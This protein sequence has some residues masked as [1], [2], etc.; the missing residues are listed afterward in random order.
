MP[1][2]LAGPDA[3]A[4]AGD[5]SEPE[6]AFRPMANN[7]RRW[8]NN[9]AGP[10]Y[11]DADCIDCH[12]CSEVAPANFQID[13][14]NGHDFVYKQPENA[15]EEELCREAKSCCPVSAIGDDG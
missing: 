13:G 5:S 4:F 15:D 12:L 1:G 8:P 7:S 3:G 9:A 6:P 11:V 10:Y 2:S 14:E